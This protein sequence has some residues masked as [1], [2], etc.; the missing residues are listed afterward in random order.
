MSTISP[1]S[2]EFTDNENTYNSAEQY[3]MYRKAKLF[4]DMEMSER[5]LNT[6]SPKI[7]KRLGRQVINFN[8]RKY[9]HC[10]EYAKIFAK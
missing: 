3:M 4:G 7:A 10:W 6:N 2:C 1:L 8:Q 5:I 9:C